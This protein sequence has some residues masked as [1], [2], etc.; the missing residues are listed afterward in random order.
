M[1]GVWGG[2]VSSTR[3]VTIGSK[4]EPTK[5]L[6]KKIRELGGFTFEPLSNN[7]PTT[8]FA[9]SGHKDREWIFD[10]D[11]FSER[12]VIRFINKNT[13]LLS[14]PNTHIGAWFDVANGK[15]YLDISIIFQNQNEAVKQAK[16]LGELAIYSLG[17]G[18]TIVVKEKKGIV[19]Y[20]K[21][22]EDNKESVAKA[23]AN[24]ARKIFGKSKGMIVKKGSASSGHHGHGGLPGVWGGSKPSGKAKTTVK[25]KAKVKPKATVKPK[26]KPKAKAQIVKK[27]IEEKKPDKYAAQK[28][29]LRDKDVPEDIIKKLEDTG[30]MEEFPLK[31]V[32]TDESAQA[33]V[34]HQI[35]YHSDDLN[36]WVDM[37]NNA[38]PKTAKLAGQKKLLKD[39][40]VDDKT[41]EVVEASGAMDAWPLKFVDSDLKGIPEQ[42]TKDL[43]NAVDSYQSQKTNNVFGDE[44]AQYQVALATSLDGDFGKAKGAVESPIPVPGSEEL[45]E[46]PIE[47]GLRTD[48]YPF[49]SGKVPPDTLEHLSVVEGFDNPNEYYNHLRGQWKDGT[50]SDA[51]YTQKAEDL[52]PE[53]RDYDST[54]VGEDQRAH[55]ALNEGLPNAWQF[56]GYDERGQIKDGI[57]E[58]LSAKTGMGYDETNRAIAQWSETSNDTDM[59]SLSLQEAAAEE[60]GVDLSDWQQKNIR[61]LEVDRDW[62]IK[63]Q[64]GLG[65]PEDRVGM[66]RAYQPELF[67]VIEGNSLPE[68][69]ARERK[70]INVMYQETQ[71]SLADAGYKPTDF[72]KLYRGF[73]ITKDII[74]A[75]S[76]P[77]PGETVTYIGNPMESWSAS[78]RT[79]SGFGNTTISM[80]VPVANIVGTSRTG[81]GCV[82][83]GEYIVMAA[84][85]NQGIIVE[86]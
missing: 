23:I 29:F 65:F 18:E 39:L 15:I 50:I 78:K 20:A 83:E 32:A 26:A 86:R 21:V 67:S 43:E 52:A 14:K 34:E 82:R 6:T 17:S 3:A 61:K 81:F 31:N 42:A 70:F 22:T 63:D 59:R 44:E 69:R 48:T 80:W 7:S 35:A 49:S 41:I 9:V 25:P 73:D 77:D 40:G 76:R 84:D 13:Q 75:K 74:S 30:M 85:E 38:Y 10:A 58:N 68:V 28:K 19:T 60:F 37:L 2:S 54:G 53:M 51:E 1:S 36:E 62:A 46:G 56:T 27:P 72:I 12:D 33:G 66:A 16:S 55:A 57:V 45:P 8:G 64:E 24:K 5:K 71:A 11:K 47:G 79:A 4:P